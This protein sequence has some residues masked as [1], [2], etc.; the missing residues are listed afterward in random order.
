MDVFAGKAFVVRVDEATAAD[1]GTTFVRDLAF[2][3][4]RRVHP[5]LIAPHPDAAAQLVRT[6]NRSG[7]SAVRLNGA[8]AALLPTSGT[9]I[10]NVQPGILRTLTGAGYIPV[11]EPTGFEL[12]AEAAQLNADEV[13]RA[14]AAATDAVRAIF[15]HALG[16][17]IDPQTEAVISELT[18]AEALTIADDARVP[19]DLRDAIRAAAM[20]VR[21]GVKSA[22][23]VD[24]RVAHA[25]IVELLTAHHLGTRVTSSIIGAVGY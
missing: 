24:G 3:A 8:D 18:P 13:A 2:L 10:G 19:R 4:G 1:A 14:V 12:F 22:Q 17:V 6:I 25:T 23:I 20:G 5:I 21:D 15:F 11:V 16:G 9:A 7:N